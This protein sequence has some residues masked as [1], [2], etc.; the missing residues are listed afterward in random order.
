MIRINLLPHREQK[1][2]ARMTRFVVLVVVFFLAGG[3]AIGAGYLVF[4]HQIDRQSQ[5]NNFISE[6]NAKLDKKIA[7]IETLKKECQ[8]L[9][10]R[11]KVVALLQSNRSESVRIF[12]KIV[13][14]T[15]EGIYLKDLKQAN[16]L[17]TLT[18]YAQSSAKVSV[19]MRSLS[20]SQMF[21]QP[22][23]IEIKAAPVCS[24]RLNE[25]NLQLKIVR[26]QA[27]DAKKGRPGDKP[28][29]GG[30]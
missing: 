22:N 11:T 16:D 3:F 13:R 20:D 19:Y 26:D 1:R 23:L 25:F 29:V 7:Q 10:D 14:Q 4:D 24:Q 27:A 12:D 8:Q 18:G 21:E 6:E 15:P 17:I 2:K 30:A 5:R 9:L 28:K